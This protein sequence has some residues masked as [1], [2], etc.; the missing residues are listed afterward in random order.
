MMPPA[1][2]RLVIISLVVWLLVVI[3]M[4]GSFL[5]PGI[6]EDQITARYVVS[7]STQWRRWFGNCEHF[8]EW[9]N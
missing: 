7:V 8:A 1:L 2:T 5:R 3:L 9:R 6:S 4:S